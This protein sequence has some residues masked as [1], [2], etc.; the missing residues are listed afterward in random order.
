MG[1]IKVESTLVSFSPLFFF[2]MVEYRF[3][4]DENVCS[5]ISVI[6]PKLFK[7]YWSALVPKSRLVVISFKH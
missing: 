1:L 7:T 6:F 2:I 5:F 4:L 3:K